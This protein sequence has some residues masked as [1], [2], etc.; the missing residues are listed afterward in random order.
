MQI[1]DDIM[2]CVAFLGCQNKG[3]FAPKG[4][5]FFVSHRISDCKYF[6]LATA[7]HVIEGIRE[8]SE[9]GNVYI[10]MNFKTGNGQV[11]LVDHNKWVFHDDDL[12]DVA[13]AAFTMPEGND[14]KL[15][16][17]ES[18]LT[19]ANIDEIGVGVGSP[20]F[21]PGLFVHHP[22]AVRNLPIIR[23]GNIAA[24]PRERVQT[25]WGSIEA[26][27]VEA[28]S[29][30]GLSGSPVI[31]QFGPVHFLP[32]GKL[33]VD[34][35]GPSRLLGLVHGHFG[36]KDI[37]D[38][39][40]DGMIPA[41]RS[42]NMGIGIVV[43]AKHILSVIESSPILKSFREEWYQSELRRLALEMPATDARP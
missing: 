29:I 13:V 41:T 19:D 8:R 31:V 6:Y 9:D 5:A 37:L 40:E 22:G 39:D 17:T 10:R 12:V 42:V 11:L 28:R 32:D 34:R 3:D 24:M 1:P 35:Y 30:G 36:V 38:S 14:H 20:L 33:Q 27:L 25:S 23:I 21:F 2:K 4:T 16:E 43:P 7:R 18:I 26:Y 15:I